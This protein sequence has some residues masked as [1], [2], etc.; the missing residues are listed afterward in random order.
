MVALV[1]PSVSAFDA[2]F[3]TPAE[4]FYSVPDW[5]NTLPASDFCVALDFALESAF[6]ALVATDFDV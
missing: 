6:T 4:V 5:A 3:A 2:S 1:R